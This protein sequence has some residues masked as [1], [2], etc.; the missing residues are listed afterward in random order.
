MSFSNEP[1]VYL[2]GFIISLVLFV[3]SITGTI[4]GGRF[5]FRPVVTV[6]SVPLRIA[7][8]IVSIAIFGFL[9]WT[10]RHKI[11]EAFSYFGFLV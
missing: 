11:D 4:F 8:F 3:V 9:I 5:G 2:I 10:A 1:W 7:F 6:K